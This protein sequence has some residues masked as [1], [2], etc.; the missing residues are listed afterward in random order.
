M[1]V[2]VAGT[3]GVLRRGGRVER[4]R[5]SDGRID[6]IESIRYCVPHG[7]RLVKPGR[8]APAH[9]ARRR[10]ARRGLD[11]DGVP[12]LQREGAGRRRRRR[13]GCAPRPPT[14]RTPAPT[15]SPPPCGRAGW[16][17]SPSSSRGRCGYAFHDPF[18]L[19]V[20]D[21]LAEE[22]DAAGRTMLLVAQ[23][24][25]DPERAVAQLATQAVDAAVFPLCGHRDNP[26]VDHLLARGIP[27]VGSGAPVDPRVTHVLTDEPAAMRLTTRA[28]ARARPHPG[29]PPV[30]AARPV[31]PHRAGHRR[32]RRRRGLPGCRGS[33]RGVPLGR[34]SRR[35]RRPGARP[36]GRGRGGRGPA[37]ARRPGRAAADRRRRPGRP[38]RRRGDP[39]RGGARAAGAGGPHGHRLRRR[40]PAVAGPRAHDG[41]AAGRG[42]GAARWGG[43]CAAPSRAGR[44][45]TS[46]SRYGCGWGRRRRPHP[47]PPS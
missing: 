15:P 5:R 12:R 32:R 16:A 20:L 43:S 37:A 34:R 11:V 36:H 22:L 41:R 26:L 8:A 46:P 2:E 42:E 4:E 10:R 47:P 44:S 9:P 28:R 39:R 31:L 1:V 7:T 14:S 25:D 17:P 23:P 38:A 13:S 35:P 45:P 3:V 21:G 27:L 6:S 19:A 29:R 30:D 24:L 18:A 33:G 40:R